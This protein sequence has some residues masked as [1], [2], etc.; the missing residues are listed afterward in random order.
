[1]R[2]LLIIALLLSGCMSNRVPMKGKNKDQ[3]LFDTT[4]HNT[5]GTYKY[6]PDI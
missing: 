5:K 1:M 4:D 6:V 3:F 2:F